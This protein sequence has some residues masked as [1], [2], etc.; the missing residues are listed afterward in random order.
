MTEEGISIVWGLLIQ[1]LV[2][3]VTF[4]IKLPKV[5]VGNVYDKLKKAKET[6]LSIAL[7]IA[8]AKIVTIIETKYGK[9]LCVIIAVGL[10]PNV[11]EAILKSRFLM[12]IILFL[13]G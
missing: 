11:L 3:L 6:S 10:E 9:R 12:I 5:I 4:V 1:P 8:V 13:R 2:L 7:G